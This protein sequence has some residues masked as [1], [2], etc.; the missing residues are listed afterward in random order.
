[1]YIVLNISSI[2]ACQGQIASFYCVSA[3]GLCMAMQTV[4]SLRKMN[5]LDGR[6]DRDGHVHRVRYDYATN[7]FTLVFS[8]MAYQTIN[9]FKLSL[10]GVCCGLG[11]SSQSYMAIAATGPVA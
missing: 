8:L 4:Y 7:F 3:T 11:L 5:R 6:V 1:M 2:G 9:V 10:G